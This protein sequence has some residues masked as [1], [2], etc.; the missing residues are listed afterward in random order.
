MLYEETF[1]KVK[2][3]FL[4]VFGEQ[5]PVTLS[6]TAEEIPGW[7]S[8]NH[9][10]LVRELEKAFNTEFDLFDVIMLTSVEA[11]TRYL[12]QQTEP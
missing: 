12:H 6:T 2:T 5:T 1:E 8:L 4:A 9:V 10:R 11:I 3:V 7:D